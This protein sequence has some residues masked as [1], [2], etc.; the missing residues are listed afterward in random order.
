MFVVRYIWYLCCQLND[1]E[2]LFEVFLHVGMEVRWHVL[3]DPE[4]PP[5]AKQT[6]F[7]YL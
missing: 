5:A 1:A 3:Q 7:Q 4:E 2:C 6:V